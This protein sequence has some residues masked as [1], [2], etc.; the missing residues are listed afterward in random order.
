MQ[1]SVLSLVIIVMVMIIDHNQWTAVSFTVSSLCHP[2][3]S[4]SIVNTTLSNQKLM[5]MLSLLLSL[6]NYNTFTLSITNTLVT[7]LD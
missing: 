5:E 1:Y 3:S 6:S 7:R 2:Q 4:P